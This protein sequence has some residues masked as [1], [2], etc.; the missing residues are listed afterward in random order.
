[1]SGGREMIN[2]LLVDDE[3]FIRQGL[4]ILIDWEAYGFRIADE[5]ACGKDAIELVK[6]NKYD[7][8]ITDIKMPNINGIEL[9][10]YLRKQG[11]DELKI[12]VLSGYY[13]FSYAKQA[14][15]YNVTDYILKP[16]QKEELIRVLQEFKAEF[17]AEKKKTQSLIHTETAALERNLNALCTG[18]YEQSHLNYVKAKIPFST[19][20]RFIS[21]EMSMNDERFTRLDNKDKSEVVS[22]LLA[23]V[24]NFLGEYRDCAFI[25][26]D[27]RNDIYG[28]SFIYAKSLSTEK[29]LREQEYILALREQIKEKI[30]YTFN[31]YIGQMVDSLQELNLSCKSAVIARSFQ[32]YR[33]DKEIAYYDE[34]A[35]T[36][37]NSYGIKKEDLDELVQYT[38]ENDLEK[39]DECIDKIYSDLENNNVESNFIRISIDYLLCQYIYIA[40]EL[41][42]DVDRTEILQ[43]INQCVFEETL[44]RGSKKHFGKFVKE[45]AGYLAQL[46]QNNS[47]EVLK[48]VE[49]EIE[50]H[51]MENL[52][53]KYL[54]EK[55]YINSAY[56]GQIFK[57]KY[58][59]SF[60]DYLNN[61]RIDRASELLTRTNDKVC[62]IAQ[63]VGYNSLDYFISKFVAVKGKTPLQYRKQ[64]VNM[65][66]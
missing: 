2:I 34:M 17:E 66:S 43:Y 57:K 8:I 4:R 40:R 13:E 39:I 15:K 59:I 53:L 45:F 1:M 38:E 31:F 58:N 30:D 64:F 36:R 28:V 26:V 32:N 56:L 5:A 48:K 65:N 24:K 16:I 62:N 22:K 7:L 42:P 63:L 47:N 52:S 3:P 33:S 37:S 6:K 18:V 10:E 41:D 12:I 55:Y 50:G 11:Y 19:H 60:K 20:L 21:I 46:R 27:R 49:K 35:E 25:D 23:E 44:A 9:I 61:Y 29:K 51:Y 14:I 54:S